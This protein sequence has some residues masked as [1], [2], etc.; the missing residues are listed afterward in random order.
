MS[1]GHL[2]PPYVIEWNRDRWCGRLQVVGDFS[3]PGAGDLTVSD[4]VKRLC[5]QNEITGL[6]FYPVEA[7]PPKPSRKGGKVVQ[8]NAP[9]IW[10]AKPTMTAHL[11]IE[12]S[13]RRI[14]N[15]CQVC[16]FR[17]WEIAPNAPVVV[18]TSANSPLPDVFVIAEIGIV[19]CTER[20]RDLI[21]DNQ[22][23]NVETKLRGTIE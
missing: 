12:K 2:E 9:P 1:G 14:L 8:V 21:R 19:F 3:W 18:E 15:E 7:R 4:R 5:E 10:Y 6:S 11:N 22:L 17:T 23:S 13:G 20:F 16:G